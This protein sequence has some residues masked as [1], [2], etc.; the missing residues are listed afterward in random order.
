MADNNKQ[1]GSFYH[2]F[3]SLGMIGLLVFAGCGKSGP[4]R[5]DLSGNI[6][7]GGK[8]IPAGSITFMPD[9]T[10]GNSGLAISAKI[11]DGQ[12]DTTLDGEGHL[13]GPHTVKVIA[14]DGKPSDEFSEGVPIFPPYEMELDLPNDD[15]TQDIEVP[16]DW[17]AP[18]QG[19]QPVDYGP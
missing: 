2:G 12:F 13:G 5:Y 10:Q 14:L 4:P 6:T 16:A 15:G 11:Q 18:P 7:W 1:F 9:Q 17:V 19:S 8:P 3:V